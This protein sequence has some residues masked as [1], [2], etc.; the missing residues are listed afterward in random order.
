MKKITITLFTSLIFLF[1]LGKFLPKMPSNTIEKSIFWAK[2]THY[3]GEYN[4][5]LVGDSRIYRGL[6]PSHMKSILTDQNI[7]NFGYSSG[8]LHDL[9]LRHAYQKIQNTDKQK[10]MIMGVTPL[11]LTDD[12]SRNKHLNQELNRKKIEIFKYMY[13]NKYLKPYEIKLIT[14]TIRILGHNIFKYLNLEGPNFLKDHDNNYY[15]EKFSEDGWVASNVKITSQQKNINLYRQKFKKA[16]LLPE[17]KKNLL[18]T[19]R[20]WTNENILIFGFRPPST[21]EM[22]EIEN[23][24]TNFNEVDFGKDFEERG[25]IWLYFP[26]KYNSYDG[27][28]LSEES[29]IQLSIDLAE[30]IKHHLKQ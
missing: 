1:L 16:K 5:V 11:S 8:G 2:K 19:V 27:S 28:H 24:I 25:G 18:N 13:I 12:S 14:K 4:I 3:N 29:A 9:L 26:E 17:I 10:I 15:F 21:P 30:K 22:K 7:L 23:Q 6:S 20:Q